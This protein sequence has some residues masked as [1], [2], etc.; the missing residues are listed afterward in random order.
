MKLT[1][2]SVTLSSLLSLSAYAG[3]LTC[4]QHINEPFNGEVLHI[5]LGSSQFNTNPYIAKK[6]IFFYEDRAVHAE[7][8]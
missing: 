1:I 5:T 4:K 7:R 3:G 6:D 2:F 8:R